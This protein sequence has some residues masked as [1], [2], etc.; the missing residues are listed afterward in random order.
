[1]GANL[2]ETIRG[3]RQRKGWTLK[4]LASA[5]SL[6]VPYLSDLERR[7][8]VNPTLDTLT[9]IAGALGC[10]I[11]DLIGDGRTGETSALPPTLARFVR[12]DE[13]EHEVHLI[14]RRSR[15]PVDSVRSDLTSFLA[16]APKRSTGELSATDWRRLMDVYRVITEDT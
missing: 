15:Q 10:S 16:V 5:T 7:P 13:F 11:A 1:L 3:Y 4:D 9:A 6:S 2:G 12:S 14:A 8:G